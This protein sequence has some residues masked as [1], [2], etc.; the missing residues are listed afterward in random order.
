MPKTTASQKA[1][2]KFTR[3]D[4]PALGFKETTYEEQ[5]GTFLIW[6]STVEKVPYSRDNLMDSDV[7]APGAAVVV[8]LTPSGEIY[9]YIPE[10]DHLEGSYPLTSKEGQELVKRVVQANEA[11]PQESRS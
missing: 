8:E 4:L 9:F 7:Y 1:P 11:G 10:P 6:R 2:S 5:E 3:E